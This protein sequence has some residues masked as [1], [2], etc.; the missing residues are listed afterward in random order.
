LGY[1]GKHLEPLKRR[2]LG[3]MTKTWTNPAHHPPTKVQ[4]ESLQQETRPILLLEQKKLVG[5]RRTEITAFWTA[6]QPPLKEPQQSAPRNLRRGARSSTLI[7][8]L[9][10]WINSLVA[11][12]TLQR[13]ISQ[14]EEVDEVAD[15]TQG[16]VPAPVEVLTELE[17]IAVDAVSPQEVPI[18][19]GVV[20]NAITRSP[21]HH[22]KMDEG[23]AG[24][25]KA[26]AR[27][28]LQVMATL[29]RDHTKAEITTL[30][31]L[32]FKQVRRVPQLP[33]RSFSPPLQPESLLDSTLPRG[34]STLLALLTSPRS[35]TSTR[36]TTTRL[37][38][39]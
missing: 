10:R 11:K 1:T 21:G 22:D 37:P 25:L 26:N 20:I 9:E 34:S 17:V 18:L 32:P 14:E 13:M 23:A 28:V 36:V 6:R 38:P 35:R 30:L 3:L 8:E 39:E 4:R 2:L 7:L 27:A 12:C 33:F 16:V 15:K 5:R 29:T 19:G 31:P 24:V